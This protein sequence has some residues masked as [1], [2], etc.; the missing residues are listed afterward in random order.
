MSKPEKVFDKRI[1]NRNLQR[2]LVSPQEYD[3]Y[4]SA[5][6]DREDNAEVINLDGESN[7]EAAEATAAAATD[8]QPAAAAFG[9]VTNASE[10]ND[11]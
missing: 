2:K 8:A 5:L 9:G 3:Q 7:D 10:P 1:V 4:L 6:P 11:L